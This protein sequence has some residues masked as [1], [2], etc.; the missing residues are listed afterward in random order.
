MVAMDEMGLYFQATLTRVYAP[1]GQTPIVRVSPQ[2]DN[3]HF[4]GALE[5]RAGREMAVTTPEQTTDVTADFVIVIVLPVTLLLVIVSL[6]SLTL[7]QSAMR[8]L[9]A[10]RDERTARS[11]A[12]AIGEQLNHRATAVQSLALRLGDRVSSIEV[13]TTSSFLLPDF[14]GGLAFYTANGDQL[15]AVGNR[16][17]FTGRILTDLL[18]RAATKPTFSAPLTDSTTGEVFLMIAASTDRTTVFAVVGHPVV[19]HP[20]N[21]KAAPNAGDESYRISLG[22]FR[23]D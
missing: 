15:A 22:Q 3:V 11:V 8:D 1:V 4:Y 21:C 20:P 16:Q 5:V 23:G 2:R 10:E 6:G 9:V 17:V 14:D 12:R 7:H 18:G 13:L 19:W